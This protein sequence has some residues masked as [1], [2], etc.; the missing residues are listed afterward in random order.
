MYS[1]F[2]P[3]GVWCWIQSENNKSFQ[4]AYYS[5]TWV[6]VFLNLIFV[7]LLIWNLRQLNC[8]DDM[9]GRYINKLKLYPMIQIISLVPATVNRII[10]LC[11]KEE[12]FWLMVIQIVFDSLTGL[13]FSIV[14][15]FNPN[16]RTIVYDYFKGFCTKNLSED[17][18]ENDLDDSVSIDHPNRFRNNSI[19][20]Y[21]DN[22][23][24][25]QHE[26]I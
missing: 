8:N 20:M 22:I 16:V 5:L 4:I 23:I 17:Q 7:S 2:G 21:D 13:I 15:G 12:V 14:Y 18:I 6:V 3:A 10:T 1:K 25:G 9:I 24:T 26:N 11:E 19:K